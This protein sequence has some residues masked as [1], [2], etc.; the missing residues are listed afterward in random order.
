[1]GKAPGLIANREAIAALVSL[2]DSYA[3]RIASAML[4]VNVENYSPSRMLDAAD[5]IRVLIKDLSAR[6]VRWA[7]SSVASA[8]DAAA[9]PA[10][11]RLREINIYTS[12]PRDPGRRE[13]SIGEFADKISRTLVKAI[14]TAEDYAHSYFEATRKIVERFKSLPVKIA[15]FDPEDQAFADRVFNDV[16]SDELSR[17]EGTKQLREYFAEKVGGEDF[18]SI[19][20]KDGSVRNYSLRTYSELV[21]R[22]EMRNAQTRGVFDQCEDWDND[23][24]EVSDHATD[25][26]ICKPFEGM[27]FSISGNDPDYPPL[28]DEPPYHPNCLLPGTRCITPG[29]IIAGNRAK[30]RGQAIEITF[31]NGAR[32]SVTPNH[33]LLT[34]HGFAPA[35]LLC[36]G[37]DIFYCPDFKRIIT[38]S[39]KR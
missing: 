5:R 25:C 2:Y 37:D 21:A 15:E 24:V 10:G 36:E 38:S 20:C 18:I 29:G 4:S 28:E 30:Y 1:M 27:V 3:K 22:T 23:L 16:V 11:A 26:E 34:S 35:Y 14:L 31:T 12:R 19:V 8:Y 13:K 33:L 17:W 9:E 7:R 32:L 6:T 39:P